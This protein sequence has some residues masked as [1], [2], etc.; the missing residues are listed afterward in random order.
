MA[1]VVTLSLGGNWLTS[2]FMPWPKKD[3]EETS[4][5]CINT[6]SVQLNQTLIQRTS[7]SK[8]SKSRI[9]AGA[10]RERSRLTSGADHHFTH[11]AFKPVT[12]A[13]PT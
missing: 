7:L 3:N 9:G 5:A 2:T 10:D 11:R 6:F 1:T 8:W 13:L 4:D 12:Q